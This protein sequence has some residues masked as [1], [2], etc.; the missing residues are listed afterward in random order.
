MNSEYEKIFTPHQYVCFGL[1][2]D[3]CFCSFSNKAIDT[4][5]SI[6]PDEILLT[7]AASKCDLTETS[8]KTKYSKYIWELTLVLNL[9]SF[10][11]HPSTGS[12]I[13]KN[14]DHPVLSLR[15][16]KKIL[17]E[18]GISGIKKT[19]CTSSKNNQWTYL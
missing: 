16:K 11:S 19:D 7:S 13:I 17:Y 12:T 18:D 2:L 6:S 1:C 9:W 3:V 8:S 14:T 10:I 4:N 5:R 15:I